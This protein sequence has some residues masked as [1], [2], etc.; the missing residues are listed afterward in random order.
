MVAKLK[1]CSIQDAWF[2]LTVEVSKSE[3]VNLNRLQDFKLGELV[4]D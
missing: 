1:L 3:Y 4:T 2:S